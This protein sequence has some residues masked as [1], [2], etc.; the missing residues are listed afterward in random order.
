[1]RADLPRREPEIQ[2]LWEELGLYRKIRELRRGR[3][4][5]ILHDGPPYANGHI[6]MGTALNKIL[7]DFVIRYA[8][9]RGYDAPFVPG[10]D[11]HGLPIELQ[12]IRELGLDRRAI[13]PVELR[14][15]CAHFARRYIP[16]MTEEFRRLGCLG[17]WEHPYV[18]LDPA[19]E[20]TQLRAFGIMAE[21]GYIY[22]GL[23][24]VYWCAVCE[25]ALAEAEVEF[26]EKESPSIYV[27][28]P[29]SADSRAPL[30]PGSGVVIWTTTPWTLPGNRAVAANPEGVYVLVRWKGREGLVAKDLLPRLAS[31]GAVLLDR[32]EWRGRELAS[33]GIRLCH[34]FLPLEVPLLEADFVSL[35]EGTGLVHIAPGHGPEDFELGRERGLEVAVPVDGQGIL[36]PEA[37]IFSGL[38]V[39]EADEAIPRHLEEEGFLLHR[40]RILHQ[41]AHCWRCK[42]PVL[43]RAT[44][45]WFASVEGFRE[46]ALQAIRRVR[47]IPPWGETRITNMVAERAD[48]CISRQRHWGVPIPA[49]YCR[50]CGETILRRDT[51]EAVARVVEKEGTNAWY[52]R[53][54]GE[55]VPGLRC[56]RCG[57]SSFRKET[58]TMDVWFDSGTSHLCVLA[59][60]PEL[61]WP[62]D[63]YLEGS[64]QHRGWF[65]SS[66]LTAVAVKG[67]APYRAVLT[68]GFVVDGEGRKMSKSLG[69]VV[70]PAEVI[71]RWGADI[72][73]LWVA[74]SDY[75]ADIRVSPEI[76]AQL[77]EV[78]R[79]IRNTLRYLL[80]NLYD[81][82]P[83]E[84]PPLSERPELD[85]FLL[86]RLKEV[87][88][89]VRA[90]YDSFQYHL[91]HQHLHRFCVHELSSV[92]LEAV[93]DRLYC[94]LP[95]SPARRSAQATMY[96]VARAL[97]VML[98]PILPHTAEEA[99]QN[100][101][102]ETEDPPSVHLLSWPELPPE[103]ED[104][105]LA[106]RW[107]TILLLREETMR[108]L[109][110]A[111]RAG[112]IRDPLE[113]RV[114]LRGEPAGEL[115]VLGEE[116]A[117]FLLVS[118]AELYPEAAGTAGAPLAGSYGHR[119]GRF[120][121]LSLLV[122]PSSWPK[123]GRC[124]LRRPGVDG[125]TGLCRRCSSVVEELKA[126]A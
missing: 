16:V 26:Q 121:D 5:F 74:S 93:K 126:R 15:K 23:K 30:P 97:L 95:T 43:F 22:K 64:D 29:L 101:P 72:L 123:C 85:R 56:P 66:L 57:G 83:R 110:E 27:F 94:E 35:Q 103:W 24:P 20:A 10:W 120:P 3:E 115:G 46:K 90:A 11:T 58:D 59:S 84:S 99:W 44:E 81:Y 28:F 8:T 122:S 21:R 34:P 50:E 113:A 60:H 125:E 13:S 40:D 117:P 36:T 42:S 53:E 7:K 25:T 102:R 39:R 109:E 37:G 77:A 31:L 124:W 100:L 33:A 52:L 92:Y 12:A 104:E 112:V 67:E 78:Y 70:E 114:E 19:Y 55:L 75:T 79:K 80:A 87:E 86:H 118:E 9:L 69:N 98:A 107:E 6:H 105:E 65:Q 116:L 2:R 47:W 1:M 14:E 41:Y 111:K 88:A 68:H 61:R 51:V 89:R 82:H 96:Q 18:T 45:Q 119:S 71:G 106:R 54:P 91:V 38:N 63:L 76:L 4:K 48:W 49:F 73:R 62:A 32:G 108:A 17:D